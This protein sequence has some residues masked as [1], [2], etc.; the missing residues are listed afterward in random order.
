MNTTLIFGKLT[1]PALCESGRIEM[2]WIIVLT[3]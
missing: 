3:I 1:D 2:Q